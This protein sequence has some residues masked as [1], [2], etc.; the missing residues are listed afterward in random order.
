MQPKHCSTE[1]AHYGH[2]SRNISTHFHFLFL[3][4]LQHP[5]KFKRQVRSQVDE[6]LYIHT[7]SFNNYGINR[8][9]NLFKT[10]SSFTPPLPHLRVLVTMIVNASKCHLRPQILKTH[11]PS[12]AQA[13]SM[14]KFQQ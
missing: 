4:F 1:L 2:Y 6:T 11:V 9:S 14:L 8:H 7:K 5:S 13:R 3:L 12:L 10:S